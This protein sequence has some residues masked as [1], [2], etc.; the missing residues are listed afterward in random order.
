M[1]AQR[2]TYNAKRPMNG[3]EFSPRITRMNT[4]QI[5]NLRIDWQHSLRGMNIN[6][7]LSASSAGNV[8][9]HG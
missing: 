4:D 6:P 7:R 2:L 3:P 9:L 1:N 8:F 5:L